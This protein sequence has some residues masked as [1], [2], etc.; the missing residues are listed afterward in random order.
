VQS[1][2]SALLVSLLL[3]ALAG[4]AVGQE[5][6]TG[7]GA[8]REQQPQAEEAA[9]PQGQTPIV[10]AIEVE[11]EHRYSESQLRAALGQSIGEPLDPRAIDEGIKR[12]W[13]SFHVRA[14]TSY[15]EVPGGMEIR[16]TV[17]E[18]PSDREPRFIGND[19]I[20]DKQIEEWALL[21]NRAELFV[22]Q[23][24][25]VRQRIIEGYRREGFYF[26]EV[27][28]VKREDGALPDVIF[29]IREGPKVR[30]KGFE[31]RGNDSMPDARFLYFFKSGLSHLAKRK[32]NPPSLFNWRGTP[33]VE[34]TLEADLLAMRNVYRDRGWLDAVVEVEELEFNDEHTGVVIHLVVDEGERYVV[35]KL[36]IQAVE[37]E[38]PENAQDP[39]TKPTDLVFDEKKLLRKCELKPGERYEKRI[40]EKDSFE[41]RDFYGGRGYLAHPSL[42]RSVNWEFLDPE[43]TFDVEHHQV[44]VVY[45]IH[46]GRRLWIGEVVFAG[47]LHTR[48][49]VLRREVSVFPGQ[50]A[51]L[52]EIQKS[53]ARIQGTR[54]FSDEMNRLEHHDPTYSF[55]A[56]KDDPSRVDVQFEVNEGR[57]VEFNVSGGIDS[58]NGAFGLVQ[59][60]MRN[61]DITDLPSSFWRSFSEIYHKEAFHGA[62]QLLQI[63]LSPGTQ[64]SRYRL[65]F[66][67]PDIFR[68]HL[69]P[70]SLD[71]D[72]SKRRRI[73]STHEEDRTQAAVRL[74]RQF[75]YDFWAAIGVRHTTLDLAHLDDKVPPRLTAQAA[76][77]QHA[78]QGVTF[79]ATSRSLD[80]LLVPHKGYSLRWN[81]G[82]YGGGLGGEF[83]FWET[84]FGGDWYV[85]AY[86]KA[87]G[88][89]P[90][91]HVELD[92]GVSQPYGSTNDIP[93]SERQFIGGS[94][95]LRGFKFREVGPFDPASGVAEGGETFV[96]GSF[97]FQYPLYSV[98]QPGTY[99]RLE[100]LRG[101]LFLDY[102]VLDQDPFMLDPAELRTSA[103]FGIGL[104]WP[105]PITLNFGFPLRKGA[106]DGT[107]VFSFSLGG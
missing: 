97:E 42:D 80:N 44:E 72:L 75:S 39:R 55:I 5:P 91:V 93:Y 87:D 63:E 79:D 1:F 77:G 9:P 48:D 3:P 58:N 35:S 12:L 6:P 84:K 24:D 17:T 59:L 85:P 81:N 56:S 36:S 30:V 27:N 15:R 105:I 66:V 8:A 13:S 70:I 102:G 96:S 52:K 68:S 50:P 29:E 28:I 62:G 4:R 67:E 40:Q 18:L 23:A 16:L 25:R 37:W 53:L 64:V 60:T 107:Q 26:A 61:F 99:Q 51:N 88:T 21:Q 86:Q 98:V 32:L 45:R 101:T 94:R 65:R 78:F 54:F 22:Y 10:L 34:E 11:G 74:G 100:S 71:L 89:E 2:L 57:V 33:F 69:D 73:Y 95:T 90:T 19:L 20:S 43:L 103:G 83:D 38:H 46:Q 41:L 106:G 49:R 104:A 14:E 76:L 31:I 82:L 7:E 92:T 47:S